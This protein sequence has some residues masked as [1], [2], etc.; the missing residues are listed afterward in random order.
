MSI[1]EEEIENEELI[2]CLSPSK[3]EATDTVLRPEVRFLNSK[4]IENNQE[5]EV[6]PISIF[7]KI[8]FF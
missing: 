6:S 2:N 1:I 7:I 5:F 3:W 4:E 8:H